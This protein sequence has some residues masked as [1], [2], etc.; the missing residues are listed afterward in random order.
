MGAICKEKLPKVRVPTKEEISILLCKLTEMPG[1]P[2]GILLVTENSSN[3]IPAALKITLPKPIGSLFKIDLMG[4]T[5][6]EL[7]Q[8]SNELYSQISVTVEQQEAIS[9]L[10]ANQ[11]DSK[12][13]FRY[14]AYRITASKFKSVLRTS[15]DKPSLSLI[16]QICYPEAF[17]FANEATRFV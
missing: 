3:F 11:S 16:K 5:L 4:S 14:R 7:I 17:Q 9:S 10:T 1:N 6:S 2:A 12:N 13:W 15:I 8:K